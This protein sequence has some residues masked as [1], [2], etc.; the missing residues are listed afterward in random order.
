MKK[1]THALTAQLTPENW[2]DK[3]QLDALSL[4]EVADICGDL[5]QMEK[6]AKKLSGYLKEFLKAHM[7]E[8]ELDTEFW[9]LV[10]T[11]RERA[12]G[13]DRDAI[14]EEMGEDWIIDHS[15]ESTEYTELRF[16][17]IIEEGK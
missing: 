3:L 13:L 7:P 8:D 14:L 10:R 5:N 17:R 11:E 15:K 12:G 9:H 16:A 4:N 1:Y 6:F 2:K